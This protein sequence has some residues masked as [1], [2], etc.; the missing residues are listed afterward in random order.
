LPIV[1]CYFYLVVVVVVFPAEFGI[2]CRAEVLAFGVYFFWAL[3]YFSL[4]EKR[5]STKSLKVDYGICVLVNFIWAIST[6][7]F[8]I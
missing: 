5:E 3:A 6:Y 7:I 8:S 4:A 1:G 2:S